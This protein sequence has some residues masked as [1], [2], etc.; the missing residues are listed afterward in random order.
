MTLVVTTFVGY[1]AQNAQRDCVCALNRHWQICA[2]CAL[3]CSVAP[4][5]REQGAL[6]TSCPVC[7]RTGQLVLSCCPVR[8]RPC[9]GSLCYY[10]GSTIAPLFGVY[11]TSI[12][13][14][15]AGDFY[16]PC[17]LFISGPLLVLT[18]P[19]SK[20]TA[21]PFKGTSYFGGFYMLK[22]TNQIL[23]TRPAIIISKYITK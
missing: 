20:S 5:V 2:V 14:G 3:W 10:Y 4:S 11:W 16:S 15:P 12:V 8:H 1:Y 18:G 7:Q 9:P 19:N 23:K 21:E 17:S 13:L 22:D 6:S